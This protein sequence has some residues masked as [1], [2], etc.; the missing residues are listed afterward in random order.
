MS[1]LCKIC[2]KDYGTSLNESN[3]MVDDEDYWHEKDLNIVKQE[4]VEDEPP[5]TTNMPVQPQQQLDRVI[6]YDISPTPTVTPELAEDDAKLLEEERKKK[7]YEDTLFERQRAK[8]QQQENEKVARARGEADAAK[9][10]LEAKRKQE[11][12]PNL[13]RDTTTELDF[14]FTER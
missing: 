4:L 1:W 6:P 10:L 9:R 3:S 7:Q 2:H 5:S 14:P 12:H 8:R 11:I 13:I